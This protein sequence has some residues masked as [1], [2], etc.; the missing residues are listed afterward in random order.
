M[1]PANPPAGPEKDAPAEV[2]KRYFQQRRHI[3]A[4]YSRGE[5]ARADG[6]AARLPRKFGNVFSFPKR[7]SASSPSV[8]SMERLYLQV[9]SGQAM[10]LPLALVFFST[11][12]GE[13]HSGQGSAMGQSHR[14]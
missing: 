7:Y 14:A 12:S 2:L 11:S 5:T 10:C 1:I 13:P 8:S 9:F 6:F 3:E 4:E